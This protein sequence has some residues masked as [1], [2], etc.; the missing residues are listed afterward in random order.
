LAEQA[1]QTKAW[2]PHGKAGDRS[3]ITI[4]GK[5]RT[6]WWKKDWGGRMD[7]LAARPNLLL[8]GK[9]WIDKKIPATTLSS[10]AGGFPGQSLST[11]DHNGRYSHAVCVLLR[12]E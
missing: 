5:W 7:T 10:M 12:Y 6:S 1:R 2:Q 9:S 4:A 11:V 8:G 3:R